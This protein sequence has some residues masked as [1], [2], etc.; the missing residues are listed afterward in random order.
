MNFQCSEYEQGKAHGNLCKPLCETR[1]VTV[2]SCQSMHKGKVAVF[3]A[4]W[5]GTIVVIKSHREKSDYIPL[6]WTDNSNQVFPDYEELVEMI[7]QSLKL[8]FGVSLDNVML[9]LFPFFK[10]NSE[11][12]VDLMTN[13]WQLSQDNEY[14]MLMTNQHSKM[15]PKILSTCG[16]FYAVEYAKPIPV[17]SE[18]NWKLRILH[19]KQILELLLK[20]ASFQDPIHICDVKLEHFGLVEDH[21]VILDADTVFPRSIVERSTSDGRKCNQH[22]DCNLF[23]CHLLCNQITKR[24]DNNVINSNLQ[25]ICEKIFLNSGL[26]LSGNLPGSQRILIEKCAEGGRPDAETYFTNEL[27]SYFE[28]QLRIFRFRNS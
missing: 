10:N 22:Q 4:E 3:T 14:V 26:L 24:C 16:T 18:T 11:K 21:V 27:L 23:D 1:D 20:L 28:E 9:T 17:H 15:F 19:S 13:L 6:Y 7:S 5:N 12:T 8:N 25:L 2:L